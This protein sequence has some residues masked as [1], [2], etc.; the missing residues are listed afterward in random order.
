[1]KKLTIIF[2]LFLG[3]LS[4]LY[5]T[6]LG[7]RLISTHGYEN[8]IELSNGVCRVVLEP[9]CGGRVLVYEIEGKNALYIDPAQNGFMPT[10]E[11]WKT[12]PG[13]YP[14]A[15][16]FCIGPEKTFQMMRARR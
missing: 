13:T 1:M 14:C 4:T 15:G 9:N 11:E 7:S 6:P 3:I 8:C 5:A 2:A 16:R 12:T 10:P